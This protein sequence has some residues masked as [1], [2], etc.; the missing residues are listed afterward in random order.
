VIL[1]LL[2]RVLAQ[3]RTICH[4]CK[5]PIPPHMKFNHKWQKR[6]EGSRV[7]AHT[8]YFCL[9]AIESGHIYGY[10]AAFL[11]ILTMSE[12]FEGEHD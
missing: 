10:A 4:S 12:F 1:S 2:K 11:I 5:P 8:V 3:C 9:V 7:L 6:I